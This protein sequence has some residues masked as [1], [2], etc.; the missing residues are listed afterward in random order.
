MLKVLSKI[1]KCFERNK[2]QIK[3]RIYDELC[4]TVLL[5]RLLYIGRASAL[6]VFLHKKEREL[7]LIYK[8]QA[9]KM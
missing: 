4:K 2:G 5:N 6:P 1:S 3:D 7:Y 8:K 9:V